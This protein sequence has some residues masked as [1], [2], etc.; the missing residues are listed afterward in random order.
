MVR[1]I[2]TKREEITVSGKLK[3]VI[4]VKDEKG[5]IIHKTVYPIMV[6]FYLTDVMQVIIGSSI[7]AMPIAFTEETWNLGSSLPMLNVFS[8]MAISLLFISLFV[9]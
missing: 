7:L 1:K 6:E 8:I 2:H 3:E 9:Y 5:N 4:T